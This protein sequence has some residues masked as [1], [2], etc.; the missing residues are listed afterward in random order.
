MS[1]GAAMDHDVIV[2]GTG[3]GGA[4]AA[5]KL[6][7]AGMKVSI[8]ERGTWWGAADGHRQFPETVAQIVRSLEGVNVTIGKRSARL[9]LSRRGLLE[10]HLLGPTLLMNAIGVGGTSLV[11]SAFM[12]RP[13]KS[14]LA[15]LPPEVN[16]DELEQHF[17]AFE[18]A[19]E[20]S[21]CPQRGPHHSRVERL[22]AAQGWEPSAVKQNIRWAA[23]GKQPE[24][25][26]RECSYCNKCVIGCNEGAK[27]SLDLALVKGAIAAGAT[28]Q[29][30]A[31]VELIRPTPAGYEVSF[32]NLRTGGTETRL[33][34]R[35]V[36]AAGTLNTLKILFRSRDA[37]GGLRQ[38]SGRLGQSASLGADTLGY[39]RVSEDVW[40]VEADAHSVD[41]AVESSGPD[42][43]RDFTVGLF[44]GP[45]MPGSRLLRWMQGRRSLLFAG[46]ARETKEM[47]YGWNGPGLGLHGEPQAVVTRIQAAMD[48]AAAEFGWNGKRTEPTV[49][50]RSWVS[51]H[52]MGGCRM[53]GSVADGVVDGFGEAFGHAGLYVA[54]ASLLAGGAGA[55]PGW[56]IAALAGWISDRMI[57]VAGRAGG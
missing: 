5:S 12:Q 39:Y 30:L 10:M 20:A 50:K 40:P 9:G 24:P 33:A 22:V 36:L 47:T 43:V 56:T 14:F 3:Y 41:F 27:R 54:D 35:V 17:L 13:S 2:V 29:D 25:G 55:A 11:N 15:T 16:A 23:P 7:R 57:T 19:T 37:S 48:C 51:F 44:A 28:L 49:A 21:P 26:M 38:L 1:P 4:V 32:K 18:K 6:A 52:P 34:R 46:F 53:A 8:L 42:G 45:L 31:A